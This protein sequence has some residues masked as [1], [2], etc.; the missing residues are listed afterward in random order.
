[1][2]KILAL[3]VAGLLIFTAC[4]SNEAPGKNEGKTY[5][6]GTSVLNQTSFKD[7]AFEANVTYTSVALDADGKIAYVTIDAAQN[8]ILVAADGT[9]TFTAK[10]TKKEQKMDYGLNWFEQVAAFEK[11]AIGKTVQEIVDGDPATDLTSS[12]SIDVLYS[13]LNRTTL[14]FTK[15]YFKRGFVVKHFSRHSINFKA[16]VI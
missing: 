9:A 4:A 2:K 16:D 5:K 7:G 13:N 1:M 10:G 14:Y 8:K 12:V 6:V 3:M 11:Y 15:V